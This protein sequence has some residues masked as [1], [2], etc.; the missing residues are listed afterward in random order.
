MLQPQMNLLSV[1]KPSSEAAQRGVPKVVNP[2]NLLTLAAAGIYSYQSIPM[3]R[4]D[5]AYGNS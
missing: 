4:L 1:T 2:I 3:F 5:P